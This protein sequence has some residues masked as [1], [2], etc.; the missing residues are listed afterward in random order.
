MAASL[1]LAGG[2]FMATVHG[3]AARNLGLPVVAVAGRDPERAAV[4]ASRLGARACR[5]AD[6]PAG[7]DVVIVATPPAS[8]VE[9]A[10]AALEAGAGVV[11][12]K[13]LCTS[14]ADADR[15]V[16]AEQRLPRVGYAEN[17]AFAPVVVRAVEEAA[18]LG[19][20]HHLEVRAVQGRPTWGAFLTR[21]WGGGALFD[22]GVHPLAVALLLARPAPPVAVAARLEGAADHPTDEHAEVD[23]T[24]AS[25]LRARVVASWASPSQ[26]WDLQAASGSGVVRAELLP[27]PSLERNG[28]PV[29]LP[30][31]TA[32]PV[33]LEQYG[34]VGQLHAFADDITLGRRPW[35]DAAFG[36]EVLDVVCGA[37]ASA[38]AGGA[39]VP[40]PFE[41]PR[42]RTPLELWRPEG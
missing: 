2:G 28:E 35:P 6:L 10:L 1:A 20:L 25:G 39:A 19:P 12:E 7:A 40:L 38:A 42:D 3:L 9:L 24:F 22:L 33:L 26:A 4:L 18:S 14:L 11:V 13:P 30:A 34:Y 36:R 16:E 21:D 32:D 31:A 37:Y 29:G 15:L 23:L 41:G 27:A 8:H 5:T 17:L